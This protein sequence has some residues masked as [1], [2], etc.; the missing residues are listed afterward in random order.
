M[1]GL[2]LLKFIVRIIFN[3]STICLTENENI[4]K[5]PACREN[6]VYKRRKKSATMA[7]HIEGGPCPTA[8]RYKRLSTYY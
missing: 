7:Y 5:K 1:S 3:M 8:G 6:L 4:A 2:T